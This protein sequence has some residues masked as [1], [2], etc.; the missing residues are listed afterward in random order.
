MP[1]HNT[2]PYTTYI[3]ATKYTNVRGM[4]GLQC[5]IFLYYPHPDNFFVLSGLLTTTCSEAVNAVSQEV[6]SLI[7]KQQ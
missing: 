2:L 3:N 1:S 4:C 5:A 7:Q 6:A